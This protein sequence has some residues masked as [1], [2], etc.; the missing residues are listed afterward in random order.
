MSHKDKRSV[1]TDALETLG[2]IH[3]REE[4]RD[5]IHLGV[6]P[7]EAGEHLNPSE[8]IGIGPDGKAYSSVDSSV[9]SNIKALG[10]ADPFLTRS[11]NPGEKFWL[12]VY[13]RQ[14]T[15]LRHVWTHPDFDSNE[16]KVLDISE[17][18]SED[19]MQEIQRRLADNSTTVEAVATHTSPAFPESL[20]KR[21]ED[22]AWNWIKNYADGL[23]LDVD[24]LMDYA[25]SWVDAR[26]RGTWGAYLCKGSNLEGEYVSDEFWDN[27]DIVRDRSTDDDERGSFFTCSC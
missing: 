25:D 17:V 15:S 26:R 20:S 4:H 6:E 18:T 9:Y 23:D 12:V 14:I 2:T 13:P 22:E 16:Q 8:H 10:I 19:L 3:V 7:V 21:V 11:I 24:E 27:Y 5:A 1:S